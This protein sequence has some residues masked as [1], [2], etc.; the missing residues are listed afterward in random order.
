MEVLYGKYLVRRTNS[1]QISPNNYTGWI[2]ELGP[3][4]VFLAI[5]M[6]H[7]VICDRSF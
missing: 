4:H 2:L 7:K 5:P 6:S 1:R 3:F